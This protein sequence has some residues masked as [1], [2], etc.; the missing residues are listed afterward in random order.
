MKP[1]TYGGLFEEG[2]LASM[3]VPTQVV[4]FWT[5]LELTWNLDL[6]DISIIDEN[7]GRKRLQPLGTNGIK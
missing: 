6:V 7:I 3:R 1:E 2:G 5:F 4:M